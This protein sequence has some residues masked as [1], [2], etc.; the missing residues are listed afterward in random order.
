MIPHGSLVEYLGSEKFKV[1][2]VPTFGNRGILHW[3]SSRSRQRS[4]L[5]KGGCSLPKIIDDP[6]DIDGPVIVKYAGAKGGEGYFIA[7][8]IVIFVEMSIWIMNLR[9]KNMF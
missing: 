4:W 2:E 3:E 9:Y 8:I 1:L 6:H 5:E 7:G